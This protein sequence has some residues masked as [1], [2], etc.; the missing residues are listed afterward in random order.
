MVISK[1]E[2]YV[3]LMNDWNDAQCSALVETVVFGQRLDFMVLKIFSSL[4]NSVIQVL[5]L[6]YPSLCVDS[7]H[8]I[9]AAVPTHPIKMEK[10]DKT[11]GVF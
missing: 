1:C 5:L 10:E 6:L 4:N 7:N 8:L 2:I 11:Q 3:Q 9:P